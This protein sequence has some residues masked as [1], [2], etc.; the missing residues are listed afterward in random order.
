MALRWTTG[1]GIAS[2]ALVAVL[3][4]AG[5][6]AASAHTPFVCGSSG[7]TTNA[8]APGPYHLELGWEHEPPLVDQKNSVHFEIDQNNANTTGID[9]QNPGNF[10]VTLTYGTTTETLPPLYQNQGETGV[11]L[12][13][14]VPTRTGTYTVHVTGH[15]S[16]NTPVDIKADLQNVEAS[17]LGFPDTTM[18]QKNLS[19]NVNT[20]GQQISSLQS[21]QS[22]GSSGNKALYNQIASLQTDRDNLQ[23]LAWVGLGL[24][25]AGLLLG[26]IA[27]IVGGTAASRAR[28]SLATQT[29]GVSQARVLPAQRVQVQ[30][31]R[32]PPK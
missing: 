23:V 13:D 18:S 1:A 21:A 26:L 29:A 24:G 31:P 25:G 5:L 8:S 12:A 2:A 22:D 6:P 3:T 19:D 17:T 20:Q 32:Q 28:R 7:C 11:Y 30:D 15:L 4:L 9:G 14:V 10:V 27:L 16:D